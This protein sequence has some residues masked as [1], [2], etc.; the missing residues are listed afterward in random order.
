MPR[1][2]SALYFIAW[3]FL[4]NFMLLNLFLAILLD[5]FTDESLEGQ[6]KKVD[7]QNDHIKMITGLEGQKLIEYYQSEASSEATTVN[8][9]KG[10]LGQKKKSSSRKED[11]QNLLDESFEYNKEALTIKQE[12]KDKKNVLFENVDCKKSFYIFSK[13]N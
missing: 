11:Q 5:S 9:E 12:I 4:G 3:V 10:V 6:A 8:L 2:I 13:S 1:P 7:N